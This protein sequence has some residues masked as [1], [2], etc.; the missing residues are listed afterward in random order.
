MQRL[1]CLQL[2]HIFLYVWDETVSFEKVDA[3]LITTSRVPKY[4]HPS[5]NRKERLTIYQENKFKVV[6]VVRQ[7]QQRFPFS[8]YNWTTIF[9]RSDVY[10]IANAILINTNGCIHYK[11]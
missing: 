10:L 4:Q 8:P 7:K 11:T 1:K 6:A 2:R 3:R 5:H 9:V